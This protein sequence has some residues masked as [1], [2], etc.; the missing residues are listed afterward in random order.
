MILVQSTTV[1]IDTLANFEEMLSAKG[2]IFTKKLF[3][4]NTNP[5]TISAIYKVPARTSIDLIFLRAADFN[6]K[7]FIRLKTEE[8]NDEVLLS[9]IEY[10]LPITSEIIDRLDISL[11]QIQ[12]FDIDPTFLRPSGVSESPITI[13][14]RRLR[15]HVQILPVL[16]DQGR[17]VP[18]WKVNVSTY[19]LTGLPIVEFV[20][21]PN[22]AV[23]HQKATP[24]AVRFFTQDR[25]EFCQVAI[26]PAGYDNSL[27]RFFPDP[28]SKTPFKLS[29]ECP[30]INSAAPCPPTPFP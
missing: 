28:D 19:N 24:T 29:L 7:M 21:L 16:N 23:D 25:D 5:P 22:A 18:S 4:E 10:C 13:V 30:M 14:Y 3:G 8:E 12:H 9:Q 26:S 27:L 2:L 15:F 20:A 17:N 6:G 11:P 1:E